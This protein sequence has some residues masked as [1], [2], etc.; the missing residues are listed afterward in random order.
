MA[1]RAGRRGATALAAAILL[2]APTGCGDDDPAEDSGTPTTTV[3][4]GPTVTG[5]GVV[6][7]RTWVG[8]E[9]IP[10]DLVAVDETVIALAS[11][12][13]GRA[14]LLLRSTDG[15]ATWDE[16]AVAFADEVPT[17]SNDWIIA[18]IAPRLLATDGLV[19]AVRPSDPRGGP[20]LHHD[21][22]ASTDVGSTWTPLDLPVADGRS[23]LVTGV[24]ASDGVLLVVGMVQDD[25]G[26]G[27]GGGYGEHGSNAAADHLDAYDAAAWTSTDGGATFTPA[28]GLGAGAPGLQA[29]RRVLWAGDRFVA[30][31]VDSGGLPQMGFPS[32]GPVSWTSPDG[33]TWSP[34]AAPDPG[35]LWTP[36]GSV[37]APW[38]ATDD[39]GVAIGPPGAQTTLAPGAT[40]WTASAAA[41]EVVRY[42]AGLLPLSDGSAV[43]T[44]VQDSACDCEVA[45]AGLVGEG[46]RLWDVPELLFDDCE[47]TSIRGQTGVAEPYAVGDAVV[48]L[49]WCNDRGRP[50][51]AV[52]S[53]IDGG[54]Q[55]STARLTDLAPDGA[56]DVG[57]PQRP[58]GNR[59]AVSVGDRM[60][61]LLMVAPRR[62]DDADRGDEVGSVRP[63]PGLL[64]AATVAAAA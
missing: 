63:R 40:A 6:A 58:L 36:G 64:V 57:V 31:G 16:P 54:A 27:V 18:P 37:D 17:D 44:L 50:V 12:V 20:R 25:A 46:T 33:R 5:D 48:A 22:L 53:S 9:A 51:A 11:S 45:H 42:P 59:Y 56:G 35:G 41:G 24:A 19:V 13:P 52:A 26:S 23:A 30:L 10:D 34:L 21:L 29:M 14:D 8:P 15:G 43:A 28:T 47:D 1:G 2:L 49:A 4:V 7:T 61:V 32:V 38:I 39:G 60:V 3:P 55:W 62:P